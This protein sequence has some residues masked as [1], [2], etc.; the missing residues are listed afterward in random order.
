MTDGRLFCI[1][2][3]ATHRIS[4]REIRADNNLLGNV[5][6]FSA[7]V[8]S[9]LL[10]YTLRGKM[11][12]GGLVYLGRELFNGPAEPGLA[13]VA[14]A[15]EIIQSALLIHD[16]IMDR[17]EVRRG[18]QT[19]HRHYGEEAVALNSA[20]PDHVG[21]SL[22]ICVGDIAFFIGFR[23][24]AESHLEAGLINRLTSLFS[25]E[26][27]LVGVA[28]MEDVSWGARNLRDH[29][30]SEAEILNLYRYKKGRYTFS[31]PLTAGALV[32]G[33]GSEEIILLESLGEKLG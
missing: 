25:R 18:K 12:R 4:H 19:L 28:Q 20:D 3:K 17:D 5:N 30:A 24:I 13:P 9:R 15:I 8:C 7:D 31:L 26:M 6:R 22:G 27:G 23:L 21:S 33:R 16:D 10:D 1:Q 29:G 14:A 32:A 2:K 11:I